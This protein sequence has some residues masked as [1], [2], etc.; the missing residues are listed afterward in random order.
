MEMDTLPSIAHRLGRKKEHQARPIK[1]VME[2]RSHK[3][4]F[5][6]KL[7]NLKYAGPVYNKARVT[8]DHSWEERQ[9]IRR[10]VK[11]AKE[12]NEKDGEMT[13]Y[14]WKVRG[15]PKSGLRIV[16]IRTY[17]EAKRNQQP[18]MMKKKGTPKDNEGAL[19]RG[20]EGLRSC[21]P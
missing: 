9:E 11:M 15:T 14:L 7:S 20:L 5:M 12:K 13:N 18:Q 8:D 2:S 21:N 1:I 10:W 3:A 16:Q 17:D 6:S 4:E 19:Y